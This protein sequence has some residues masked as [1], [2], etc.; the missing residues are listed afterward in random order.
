MWLTVGIIVAAI[1]LLIG[2]G[3][4]WYFNWL[5]PRTDGWLRARDDNYF[6][7]TCASGMMT[8]YRWF[9]RRLP[10]NPRCRLCLVPFGGVGRL[11]RVR[12]SRKNPNFCMGCF[13]MAPLGGHDMEVGVLF[14]DVRGFTPWCEGRA[15]ETIE[16][17]LNA[18]YD[19][20]TAVLAERDAIIQL[21]G[22]QVMG[23]F[24]TA[25]PSLEMKACAVMV[26]AA[27][28]LL[29]RLQ[30]SETTLPVGLGLNYGVARV[31]NVGGGPVKD[32]TAVGDVVNTA[33]RLQACAGPG[34]IVMSDE[35]F[36]R[37]R[38]RYPEAAPVT[39]TVKGKSAHVHAHRLTTK[40]AG[41]RGA[42]PVAAA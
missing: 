3:V 14:A 18:F 30:L 40:P 8:R 7:N 22:D 6:F 41:A 32:F 15:P 4:P 42:S 26:R 1:L 10:A 39:L 25:F 20:S 5:S 33:A 31:G 34:E 9:N 16:Q 13:E 28:E 37:V 27:E 29:R 12:P 17:A 36:D 23:L 21:V 24:L 2:G 19:V 35:V 38:D 11:L